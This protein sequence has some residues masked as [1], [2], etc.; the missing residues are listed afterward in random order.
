MR[1]RVFAGLLRACPH[2]G[3]SYGNVSRVA[4]KE[5]LRLRTTIQ[6][7]FVD[8][9][10][11]GGGERE[12]GYDISREQNNNEDRTVCAPTRRVRFVC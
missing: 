5:N 3:D 9:T 4:R 12:R 10:D 7:G 8:V 6:C 1:V 11:V 2:L